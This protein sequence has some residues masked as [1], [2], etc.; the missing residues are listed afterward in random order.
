MPSEVRWADPGLFAVGA[1]M[2]HG[3][4]HAAEG[5]LVAIVDS[6]EDSGNSTHVGGAFWANRRGG[7]PAARALEIRRISRRSKMARPRAA[8]SLRAESS[9]TSRS[10][11]AGIFRR[12]AKAMASFKSGSI[13]SQDK[14]RRRRLSHWPGDRRRA[15]SRRFGLFVKFR[16]KMIL[17]AG[18]EGVSRL[19]IQPAHIDAFHLGLQMWP[20]TVSRAAEGI[21]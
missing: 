13:A 3:R 2:A 4:A 14:C 18:D 5:R 17:D 10:H 12:G 16:F 15:R 19:A 20:N 9:F 11:S 6:A 8:S 1:A 7:Q 21:P